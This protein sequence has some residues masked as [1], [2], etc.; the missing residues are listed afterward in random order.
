VRDEP[1]GALVPEAPAEV[2]PISGPASSVTW[3]GAPP[4][5]AYVDHTWTDIPLP[6]EPPPEEAAMT[7]PP[8]GP[9]PAAAT[10]DPI[11][12]R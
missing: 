7:P 5:D 8:P 11:I 6:P 9:G 1:V 2:H 4:L 3:A 12:E 10:V